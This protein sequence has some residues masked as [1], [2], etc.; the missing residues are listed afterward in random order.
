[1]KQKISATIL[2]IVILSSVGLAP[3]AQALSCLPTA[4]YLQSVIGD[5]QTLVF[6]ATSN[7]RTDTN[8]Y[9]S[10]VVSVDEA[11]QGYVE[12]ELFV[13]HE[14]HPDWNYLCNAGPQKEGS[15]GVY[16]VYRDEFGTH[17]VNQRL[18]LDEKITTDFI[19]N[20]KDAK[21][22]GQVSEL[23]TTDQENRVMTSIIELINRIGKLLTELKY[24]QS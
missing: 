20:L 14:R 15:T 23:S 16:V 13:Y 17:N 2:G 8:E 3:T 21:V 24:W 18:N 9:T 5:E 7:D 10:E 12:S 6:I 22:E 1:M 19:S 4:D 11:L